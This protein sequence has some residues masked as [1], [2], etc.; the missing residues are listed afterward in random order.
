MRLFSN[1]L[2]Q[3]FG[4]ER[5]E[6]LN[7]AIASGHGVE[8]ADFAFP[9]VVND[10]AV[11][12]HLREWYAQRLGTQARPVS[13][14]APFIDMLPGSTDRLVREAAARRMRATLD[15]AEEIGAEYVVV[16]TGF[17]PLVRNPGH[18]QGWTER[19]IG[20]WIE[21]LEG[22]RTR[23]LF[24]NLW[25][26]EP[27]VIARLV[28]ASTDLNTGVC[29]DVGH[30]HLHSPLS[31]TE[32]VDALGE[33][34]AYMH[35]NDNHQN[36]DEELPPGDGTVDWRSLALALSRLPVK[37][38]AVPEVRNLAAVHKAEQFIVNL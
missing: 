29:F 5:N 16:H 9:A 36:H 24:E 26:Q 11:W 15:V 23:L 21:A 22:R 2:T 35:L 17:N 30:A 3:V 20:F 37:P 18:V 12:N 38:L 8:V 32:W 25:E 28:D 10:A 31:L 6:L 34:I 19:T 27:E 1:I 4:D 7:H 13:V 14:H 33:R